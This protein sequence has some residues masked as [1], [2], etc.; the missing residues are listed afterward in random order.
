MKILVIIPAYNEEGSIGQLVRD[1]REHVKGAD[2]LVVNDC[3]TD[4]TREVLE[5]LEGVRHMTLPFN[6][7]VGGAVLA[8]FNYFLE[9]DYDVVLRM[10][11]DG[12]HP[13]DQAGP[14]IEAMAG[15]A[16]AVVG[17][18]YLGKEREYS[19]QMRRMGINLLN[20]LSSAILRKKFTDNTSG[21]RAYNR[22]AI[23]YLASDYPF[24]YPEPEEIYILTRKGYDVREV[25][26]SMKSRETG[27]TSIN[28]LRTYYFLVKVL[29][30]IFV[31][32]MIGG[33][34]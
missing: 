13:P 4:R 2:I 28:T 7:G 33:K 21:F 22:R 19:S 18:R 8:G 32:Y 25:P 34:K 16:D 9:N 10:D 1:V 15:G 6:M 11:G 12:Q 20:A 24:D 23:Q 5:S 27:T 29:L 30:T 26:V 17:S 31:K 14:L 3:S